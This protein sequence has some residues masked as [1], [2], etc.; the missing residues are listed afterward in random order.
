VKTLNRRIPEIDG[1]RGAAILL[2]LIYH[3]IA[4][5]GH[6]IMPAKLV[7]GGLLS[8]GWSGVD[9]FFVLSGF[10]IGGILLD[11]K[12]SADYFKVF[13]VRRFYRILPLYGVLCVWS[14]VVYYAHLST[15]RGCSK[16]RFLG[17][18]I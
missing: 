15:Q 10:L 2:I 9:L 3:W 18:P 6:S 16:K 13:Y 14:V 12:D 5:E 8:W 17:T 1:I 11:A 4:T 7:I